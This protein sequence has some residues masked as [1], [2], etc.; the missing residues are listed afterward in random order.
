[1]TGTSTRGCPVCG[2]F[3]HELI[4]RQQFR[5]GPLGDGYKIV[6]CTHCGAGF[7]DGVATQS[8]MDRY[9]S[10]QSKYAQAESGGAESPWDIKR[11]EVIVEQIKTCH[12]PGDARILDIGCATGGLLST[13]RAHG[14]QKILGVDPS[15]SCAEAAERLH[16]VPVRTATF[17]QMR[18]WEERFDLI[19]A[20]GV[21][22]HLR[23]V[24][25]AVRIA[26]SL[27]ETGGMLYCAVPDVEALA[28]CPNAPYQQFS[29]EHVNFFSAL[30]LNNLMAHLDMRVLESSRWK[31]EWREGVIEPVASGLYQKGMGAQATFDNGTRRALNRYLEFSKEGDL[32]IFAVID[33]LC[34]TQEPILVWGAGTLARRLLAVSRLADTNLVGFVDSNPHLHGERLADKPIIPPTEIEVNGPSILVCS[35]TFEREI[36]KAIS[37]L[38]SQPRRVIFLSGPPT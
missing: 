31:V 25:A 38:P 21:L 30:S 8:E 17:E 35:I 29:V 36:A 20:V 11:F 24:R 9:Y 33:R 32:P 28:D 13:F 22:E 14:Y 19:L 2:K 6:V 4:H 26:R 18:D 10:E 15:P 27:L 1:M 7:A 3:G 5:E 23:D 37:E 16:G 12:L 34:L